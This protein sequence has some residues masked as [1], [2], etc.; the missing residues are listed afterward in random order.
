MEKLIVTTSPHIQSKVSTQSIM[1]DVIIALLPATV[2]GTV[3]F[4][5]KA[6]ITILVCVGTAVLS[7]FVFNLL[8]KKEQ[9]VTDLCTHRC[10][11]NLGFFHSNLPKS[12]FI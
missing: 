7:E 8:A 11:V 6:L 4:G 2:A 10:I 3:L 1:R 12:I 9:T 5:W